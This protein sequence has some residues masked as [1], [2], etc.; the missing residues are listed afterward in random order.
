MPITRENDATGP[1][2]AVADSGIS[3]ITIRRLTPRGA[4][5]IPEALRL[6]AELSESVLCRGMG[7]KLEL[8][9]PLRYHAHMTRV[10]LETPPSAIP[11]ARDVTLRSI[12]SV[13]FGT[14]PLTTLPAAIST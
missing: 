13:E 12:H 9:N 6:D 7:W 10:R 4:L 11:C 2:I 14:N 3:S 1:L 8:W 5:T